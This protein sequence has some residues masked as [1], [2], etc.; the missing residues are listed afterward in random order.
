MI[1][2]TT[3]CVH[4]VIWEIM[5]SFVYGAE[6]CADGKIDEKLFN[7]Y[8]DAYCLYGTLNDY[9]LKNIYKLYLYQIAVCDYYGQY[10]ASNTENRRIYLQQAR[11]ATK[12]LKNAADILRGTEKP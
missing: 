9:D 12:L 8:I 11:F 2:W 7:R 1:D 3:A 4:P 6:C 10:Y 5:R